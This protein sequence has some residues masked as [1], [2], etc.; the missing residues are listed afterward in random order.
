MID[1]IWVPAAAVAVL[2]LLRFAFGPNET[3]PTVLDQE[4]YQRLRTGDQQSTVERRLAAEE[5]GDSQRPQ[6]APGDPPGTDECR[7]YHVTAR[8]ESRVYRLCF[9]DG[10][11]SHKDQVDLDR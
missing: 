10:R 7:F 5:V 2:L 6:R 8:A 3:D 4:T 1:A 9:T 11:L